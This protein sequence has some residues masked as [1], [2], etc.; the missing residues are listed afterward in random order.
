MLVGKLHLDYK[1]HASITIL[2]QVLRG[3]NELNPFVPEFT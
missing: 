2:F 1:V 3:P